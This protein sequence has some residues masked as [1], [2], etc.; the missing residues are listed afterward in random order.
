MA[1]KG[2]LTCTSSNVVHMQQD[3]PPSLSEVGSF[4]ARL[5]RMLRQTKSAMRRDF[6][7]A[8]R[9]RSEVQ[10]LRDTGNAFH[11]E[12][13]RKLEQ[14]A[15]EFDAHRDTL[16]EILCACGYA[17]QDAAQMIDDN[18]TLAQRCMLLN[19]N[20]SDRKGLSDTDGLMTIIYVHALEDSAERRHCES[21]NGPLFSSL[22]HM[23]LDVLATRESHAVPSPTFH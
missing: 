22:A 19:V 16:L 5:R 6:S 17:L 14:Q 18:T 7:E 2:S 12:L 9:I 3:A 13:I 21:S 20:E 10:A 1:N 15:D 8:R 4:I 11:V 23:T